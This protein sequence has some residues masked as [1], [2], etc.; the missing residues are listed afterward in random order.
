MKTRTGGDATQYPDHK[1]PSGKT[2]GSALRRM[3]GGTKEK[4]IESTPD[5]WEEDLGN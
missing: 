2:L 1:R 5:V 3:E 4:L